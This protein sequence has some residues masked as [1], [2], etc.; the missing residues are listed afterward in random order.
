[1]QEIFVK[2][3]KKLNTTTLF[4]S[5]LLMKQ[6]DRKKIQNIFMAIIIV[7]NFHF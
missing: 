4:I 1:M 5:S 2:G 7:E 3:F 6:K